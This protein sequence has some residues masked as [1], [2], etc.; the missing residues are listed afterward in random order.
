MRSNIT[1][2]PQFSKSLADFCKLLVTIQEDY[3]WNYEEVGRLDRLTQ[4]YLHSLELDGLNYSER[5]K[6]ATKLKQ[7]RQERRE[8]KNTIELLDPCVQ[9]LRSDKGKA[10]FNTI[11]EILG[12][13]RRTEE[14]MGMRTYV[15]RVLDKGIEK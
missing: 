7:C 15:P 11:R 5:A 8:C 10:F 6:L 4:D 13:T 2:P 3:A 12:K 14:R 9:Y 1:T